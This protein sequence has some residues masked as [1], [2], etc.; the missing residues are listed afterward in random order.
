[1]ACSICAAKTASF[2]WSS[3]SVEPSAVYD[4]RNIKTLRGVP[5]LPKSQLTRAAIGDS[6]RSRTLLPA[7]ERRTT[8]MA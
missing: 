7:T 5:P 1:M 2:A 3:S 8:R 4:R 6:L